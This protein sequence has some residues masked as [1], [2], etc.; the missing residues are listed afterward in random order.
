MHY[1]I[2]IT[3]PVN[4]TYYIEASTRGQAKQMAILRAMQDFEVPRDLIEYSILA[5]CCTPTWDSGCCVEVSDEEAPP[6]DTEKV[7]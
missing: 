2:R 7:V 4:Q 3:I 5:E 6:N 1:T